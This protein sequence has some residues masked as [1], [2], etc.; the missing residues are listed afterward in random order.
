MEGN[1]RDMLRVAGAAMIAGFATSGVTLSG[2]AAAQAALQMSP[3]DRNNGPLGV[4]LQGIQH[5]GV[6]VQNMD[7]AFEFYTEVLGGTEVMRDGDFHGEKI[8]NTLLLDQDIVAREEKSGPAHEPDLKGGSQRLDVRF[9]QFDNVVIELLQYRDSEQPMGNG[10][11]WAEP[12][13]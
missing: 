13:D 8:H 7:R 11:S 10:D 12:R 4:R 1:R 3:A 2:P 5:F 9:V 6:T